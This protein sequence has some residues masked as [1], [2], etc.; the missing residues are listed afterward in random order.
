MQCPVYEDTRTVIYQNLFSLDN[1]VQE[2]I[3]L[4]SSDVIFWLLGGQIEEVRN[5]LMTSFCIEAWKA[6]NNMY[7]DVVKGRLGIG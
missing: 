1:L 6:V 7:M 3:K 2:K 5:E 4:N